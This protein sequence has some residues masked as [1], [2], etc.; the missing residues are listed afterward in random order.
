M[1]SIFRKFL[2][3]VS[4]F[5]LCLSLS[6]FSTSLDGR[7]VVVNDGVFPQGLFAKTVGY[8]PGD[9]ISVA[10]IS[11]EST[12]DLLVIGALDPSEG[13]AI[14][15]SPEAA[16]AVGINKDDNNIVKITKRSGQDERVYGTA[17]IGKQSAVKNNSVSELPE[18]QEEA[19]DAF[20]EVIAEKPVETPV[21]EIPAE[22]AQV[23]ATPEPVPAEEPVVIPAQEDI[24]EPE[25]YAQIDEEIPYEEEFVPVEEPIAFEETPFVPEETAE[26]SV[27]ETLIPSEEEF[28]EVEEEEFIPEE[29]VTEEAVIADSE[30]VED[31][32]EYEEIAAYPY[33]PEEDEAPEYEEIPVYAEADDEI[34]DDTVAEELAF[35]DD[36]SPLEEAPAEEL[37][38]ADDVEDVDEGE[39]ELFYAEN[40]EPLETEE[41]AFNDTE[42]DELDA[43]MEA[44]LED[45][46][47]SLVA[48]TPED[49]EEYTAIVLVPVDSILPDTSAY[50]PVNDSS[51]EE[52]SIAEV[53]SI[54][55]SGTN[56]VNKS[57]LPAEVKTEVS[58][59]GY[60]KYM[61]S[62]SSALKS[63]SYYVQIAA[64]SSDSSI[65]SVVDSYSKNYPITIVPLAVNKQI[66]I[67]PLNVDEYAVV[68]ARFKSYGYENSFLRVIK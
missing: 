43:I 22:R 33:E 2:V 10:N 58:K 27:E 41:I 57:V 13:V 6:S 44:E 66:L 23:A 21:E 14:M 8:L 59:T 35:A 42:D 55:P 37:Y 62:D 65:Q 40:P 67:G 32:P 3:I 9:I 46:E 48:E 61:V 12:V 38:V 18:I 20:D 50:E 17:V 15:L 63:G 56:E 29:P 26:P 5:G 34:E 28:A 36:L 16:K 4:T 11:G 7:A 47:N 1:K 68:L 51:E 49:E 24:A 45:Y 30:P 25:E 53:D 31:E 52:Y 54:I 60:A 64:Y 39:G 19:A